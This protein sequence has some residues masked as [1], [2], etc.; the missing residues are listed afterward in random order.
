MDANLAAGLAIGLCVGLVIGFALG[1]LAGTRAKQLAAALK[2]LASLVKAHLRRAQPDAK[3]S[4]GAE[5]VHNDDDDKAEEEA[6]GPEVLHR[7]LDVTEDPEMDVHVEM[8]TNPV[9][10]YK[11][12]LAQERER[13]ERRM[14][15]M[16]AE[17]MSEAEIHERLG[18]G[19][20]LMSNKKFDAPLK[21]LEEAGARLTAAASST[22]AAA[23]NDRLNK[24]RN[25]RGYMSRLEIDIERKPPPE[26]V[27]S[28]L[29]VAR[30]TLMQPTI[31]R[32]VQRERRS[33]G[34]VRRLSSARMVLRSK[35][36]EIREMQLRSLTRRTQKSGPKTRRGAMDKPVS[37]D[38]QSLCEGLGRLA[39]KAEARERDPSS[40]APKASHRGASHPGRMLGISSTRSNG[41][42]GLS[43]GRSGGANTART[44]SS[45]LTEEAEEERLRREI[46]AREGA[47]ALRDADA[48]DAADSL[49]VGAARTP[50]SAHAHFEAE[51]PNNALE[52]A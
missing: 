4:S 42:N 27:P 3:A 5:D 47:Q 18:G 40:D 15:K 20:G 2:A 49:A 12:K 26:G 21:V 46:E 34:L 51:A 39:Q 33:K 41:S 1:F 24:M 44:D 8:F 45:L 32:D 17:G 22:E 14:E 19:V 48:A 38:L 9:W 36:A 11:M 43:T 23:R 16:R 10:L 28:A 25:L 29:A 13:N 35:A 37:N 6:G 50:R 52:Y 31:K 30:A 7:F